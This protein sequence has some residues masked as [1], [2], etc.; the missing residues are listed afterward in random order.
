MPTAPDPAA[1]QALSATSKATTAKSKPVPNPATILK[2]KASAMAEAALL[3]D[4]KDGPRDQSKMPGAEFLALA[5]ALAEARLLEKTFFDSDTALT[6]AV[7]YAQPQMI[8]AL[9][10]L[11]AL[12]T[13]PTQYGQSPIMQCM[14]HKTGGKVDEERALANITLLLDAG[15]NL[16]HANQVGQQAIHWAAMS[17]TRAVARLLL[18]HGADPS[19]QDRDGLTPLHYSAKIGRLDMSKILVEAGSSLSLK[20]KEL[21]KLYTPLGLAVQWCSYIGESALK[22]VAY[23]AQVEVAQIEKAALEKAAKKPRAKKSSKEAALA[24]GKPRI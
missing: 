12:P 16:H 14:A 8:Q 4:Q 7:Q 11:G 2:K 21:S 19:A 1:E 23:L 13:T 3:A 5:S 10:D 24:P 20:G 22:T 9:L 18:A 15:G 6:F 17:D